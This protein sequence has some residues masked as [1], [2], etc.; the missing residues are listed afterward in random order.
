MDLSLLSSP[1]LVNFELS[2]YDKYFESDVIKST[3]EL[4]TIK[5]LLIWVSVNDRYSKAKDYVDA[6]LEEHITNSKYDFL[7][8]VLPQKA[9]RIAIDYYMKNRF[10]NDRI[11]WIRNHH[12]TKPARSLA[13]CP[14]KGNT[15]S[16]LSP[17]CCFIDTEEPIVAKI[18]DRYIKFNQP[19]KYCL[20]TLSSNRLSLELWPC[21][22]QGNTFTLNDFLDEKICHIQPIQNIMFLTEVVPQTEPLYFLVRSHPDGESDFIA[23]D[24]DSI[25]TRKDEKEETL[26]QLFERTNFEVKEY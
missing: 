13:K 4:L 19:T 2:K 16:S 10:Y 20:V 1:D 5:D 15:F 18:D 26:I 23:V 3:C 11:D 9:Y 14:V 17:Y 21:F 25:I 22:V 12:H 6:K 7:F 8:P 24:G